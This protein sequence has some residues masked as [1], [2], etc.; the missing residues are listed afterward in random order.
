MNAQLKAWAWALGG[1]V[2]GGS[3]LAPGP[4]H[5]AKDRSLS[6]RPSASSPDGFLVHSFTGD[7]WRLCRDHVRAKL[8]LPRNS[9]PKQYVTAPKQPA[10]QPNEETECQRSINVW[11]AVWG[12]AVNPS[13]TLVEKYLRSRC[14][15]LPV[16]SAGEAIRF[17]ECCKFG[18]ECHPAMVCLVRNIVSNE[19]Q[20]I[21]RTAL[22]P[23]GAAVKRDGKTFRMRLGTILWG[24][25]KLDPDEDV[26]ERLCIGEGV[27]TCLAGRQMG[28]RPVWSA[29]SKNGVANFP[30]LP[31][32]GGVHI[33]KE[34]DPKSQ[35]AKAVEVCARRWYEAGR[36]VMVVEPDSGSKD[37]NDELQGAAR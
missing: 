18:L 35:S 10:K 33:L 30:V 13:R 27:E 24:A 1:L 25:I 21:H 26:T 8:G 9:I 31:G 37:L 17:H 6:I 14:L 12:A 4:G 23:G 15:D 28:L 7:D 22:A 2:S 20:G 11:R 32:V 19:P 34:N 16:E 29:V 3:V 36:D 5:S